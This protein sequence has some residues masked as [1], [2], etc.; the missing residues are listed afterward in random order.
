MTRQR[1]WGVNSET[2]AYLGSLIE[3]HLE[4]ASGRQ[5]KAIQGRLHTHTIDE[6]VT[7]LTIVQNT[8]ELREYVDARLVYI[9]HRPV[10]LYQYLALMSGRGLTPREAWAT[11]HAMA[12]T[13]TTALDTMLMDTAEEA[14]RGYYLRRYGSVLDETY[15]VYQLFA[16]LVGL[17]LPDLPAP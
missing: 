1:R 15:H 6:L 7:D 9:H 8:L 10:S 12:L 13:V 4:D 14:D 11:F 2:L 17:T 16:T 3:S 5:L